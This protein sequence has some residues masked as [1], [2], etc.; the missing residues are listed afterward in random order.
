MHILIAV[1]IPG[2]MELFCDIRPAL[3]VCARE[4]YCF[5]AFLCVMN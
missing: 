5:S 3:P 1:D 4:M 2:R